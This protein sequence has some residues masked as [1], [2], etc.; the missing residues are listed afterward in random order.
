MSAQH[1]INVAARWLLVVFSA[2][3]LLTV[4]VGLTHAPVRET[5]EGTLAHIFQLSVVAAFFSGL[6][7]VPT[8]NWREARRSAWALALP[9]GLLAL[10]FA[11]L[12]I[13][14]HRSVLG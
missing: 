1:N 10:A 9:A 12:Y 5:D 8:A 13:L 4:L 7:F 11:A 14:E 6:L 2:T 3:A